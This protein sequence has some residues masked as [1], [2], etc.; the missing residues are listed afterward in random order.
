MHFYHRTLYLTLLLFLNSFAQDSLTF[1]G[2][3][4]NS[5]N[6]G[7]SFSK[8]SFKD[9]VEKY[10]GNWRALRSDPED[11]RSWRANPSLLTFDFKVEMYNF[12]LTGELPIHKD[13]EAQY[14][15]SHWGNLPTGLNEVDFNLPEKSLIGYHY[16]LGEVK[17]GRFQKTFGPS[18]ERGVSLSS[19]HARDAINS[20]WDFGQFHAEIYFAALNPWLTNSKDTSLSEVYQQ[21]NNVP[22]SQRKRIYDTPAKNL[23]VHQLGWHHPQFHLNLTEYAIIGG[24]V[25]GLK[26]YSPFTAWHNNYGN[27]Y[28]N[29]S[30]ALDFEWRPSWGSA[31]FEINLDDINAGYT[32]GEGG[33][34]RPTTLAYLLGVKHLIQLENITFENRL[35]W[36]YVD[37]SFGLHDLPLL[38]ATDRQVL[39]SSYRDRS[40]PNY[41]DHYIID[42]PLG[43]YRGPDVVD[44]WWNFKMTSPLFEFSSQMGWLRKGQNTPYTLYNL[45]YR[46]DTAPSGTLLQEGLAQ[47]KFTWKFTNEISTSI[48]YYLRFGDLGTRFS[49]QFEIAYIYH[50]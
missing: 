27:G 4:R 28:T 25:P 26:E 29:S 15:N 32:G 11:L 3:I 5:L 18:P 19:T 42:T 22:K 14:Q 9:T 35:E 46:S 20:F 8:L 49:P 43:Y 33:T 37:P 17:F 12:Y 38:Q 24:R 30:L 41:A 39:T 7:T 2:S 16:A 40:K 36:V 44:L 34:E 1:A 21:S 13:F 48:G 50:L 23:M 6:W 10:D 47:Q 31:Y 45:R